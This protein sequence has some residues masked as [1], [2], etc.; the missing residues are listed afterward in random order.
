MENL[1]MKLLPELWSQH[2]EDW[3]TN[4]YSEHLKKKLSISDPYSDV[5]S[6]YLVLKALAGSLDK[7]ELEPPQTVRGKW[8]LVVF[9]EKLNPKKME[10]LTLTLSGSLA[11]TSVLKLGQRGEGHQ[12]PLSSFCVPG[13]SK[14]VNSSNPMKEIY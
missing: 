5:G 3:F 12:Y 2:N 8:C 4:L 11:V 13:I 14:W 9:W 6:D 7:Q 1:N 10:V